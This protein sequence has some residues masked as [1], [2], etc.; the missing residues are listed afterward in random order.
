MAAPPDDATLE[1]P[2]LP[3]VPG[4][5]VL[6]LLGQG[7][8]GSV[9]LAHEELLQRLVAVKL[10]S[11]RFSADD[12]ARARFLR[13][14]RAMASVEHPHVVRVYGFG[15]HQGVA[16]LVMEFIEGATLADRL[17]Q[18]GRLPVDQAVE[19]VRQV[20]Q[21]LRAAWAK[22]IVHRDLKPSNM[23]VDA[24]GQVHLADFGLAKPIEASGTD[25]T[26]TGVILGTPAY[27]SPEQARGEAVD[28]RSDFYSLG[29]VLYE[30]LCGERPFAGGTAVEILSR[31][32]NEELPS[33]SS[34]RAD[35][36]PP[37]ARLVAQM[38]RKEPAARPAS[39]ESLLAALDAS[40][41]RQPAKRRGGSGLVWKGAL[42][43]AL[44]LALAAWG[45]VTWTRKAPPARLPVAAASL[46][47]E[48]FARAYWE[49]SGGLGDEFS[50]DSPGADL[51]D[52]LKLMSDFTGRNVIVARGVSGKVLGRYRKL[53]WVL[54]LNAVIEENHL[55][56]YA[57]ESGI[58]VAPFADMKRYWGAD[59]LVLPVRA[60]QADEVLRTIEPLLSG[61][62]SAASARLTPDTTGILVSDAP[63]RIAYVASALEQL[64]LSKP[65]SSVTL[66]RMQCSDPGG[67]STGRAT[68]ITFA[69]PETGG[70]SRVASFDWKDAALTDILGDM[71]RTA[72]YSVRS[73]A[74]AAS[75]MTFRLVELPV[76]VAWNLVMATNKLDFSCDG[77]MLDVY[78]AGSPERAGLRIAPIPAQADS[79]ALAAALRET[80]LGPS[81]S[82][83]PLPAGSALRFEGR[84]STGRRV[85][86]A[87]DQ[88]SGLAKSHDAAIN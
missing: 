52:F 23:L 80:L 32:L 83:E 14:A 15:E 56:W 30:M 49:K 53:P 65:F 55:S 24:L 87:L 61:L 31:H 26:S 75:R 40:G 79:Q 13:E 18:S 22:G 5:H 63:V 21:G 17:S 69:F 81:E 6:R 7:G 77:T 2:A 38:V 27:M 74:S 84:P 34:K 60:N 50:Y 62:G 43:G 42:A 46:D 78:P 64:G 45:A 82:I 36:L 9:Y 48:T 44:G 72:G 54:V 1:Q 33:V 88:L 4:H 86:F 12:D 29:I 76:G 85:L 39:H 20:T 57:F 35:V 73:S 68:H 58:V 37:V 66:D 10:L 47:F 71:A 41:A 25:L 70:M 8:M 59:L 28:F 16:Y 67:A 11:R 3:E 51:Q 19:I